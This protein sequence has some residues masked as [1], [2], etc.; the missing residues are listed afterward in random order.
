MYGQ[1]IQFIESHLLTCPSRSFLHMD[2]PGCGLQR[3]FLALLKGNITQSLH[4]HP[5]IIPMLLLGL[6]LPVH[7]KYNFQNGAKVIIGLQAG[8]AIITFAFYVYK[9]INNQIFY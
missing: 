2:C 5:A 4:Y 1:I 8:I 9:I 6:F 3:S 7:L